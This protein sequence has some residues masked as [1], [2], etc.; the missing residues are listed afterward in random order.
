MRRMA[1]TPGA[2]GRE[3]AM[4]CLRLTIL[5]TEEPVGGRVDSCAIRLWRL[6]DCQQLGKSAVRS[7]TEVITVE[8]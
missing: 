6:G 7:T 2:G 4:S 3:R 1:V 8:G 5:R